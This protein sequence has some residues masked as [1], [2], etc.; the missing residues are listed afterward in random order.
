M[1]KI[2]DLFDLVPGWIYA[3]AIAAMLAVGCSYTSGLKVEIAH[4]EK[5][6]SAIQ[7]QLEGERAAAAKRA[8]E[9]SEAARKREKKLQDEADAA[10]K[11]DQNEIR[12]IAAQRDR[13]LD[14]LRKRPSR[15]TGAA[16]T[17]V[18]ANPGPGS[19]PAGCTGA[20]L[21]REDGEFLVRE[22]ARAEIVRK[23]LK[24][25]YAAVDRARSEAPAEEVTP[26]TED[27]PTNP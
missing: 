15:H 4:A 12:R 3:A 23:A 11:A 7:A 24:S 13:A 14:E 25:C 9:E 17:G 18:P 27:A 1:T 5:A 20:Q 8:S 16:T 26:Q 2:L 21:Y 19:A 22:S 10:R 6:A